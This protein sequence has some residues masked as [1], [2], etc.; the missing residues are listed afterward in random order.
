MET[1][2]TKLSL[3]LTG[4]LLVTDVLLRL[5]SLKSRASQP[6]KQRQQQLQALEARL[7]QAE[8]QL[9]RGDKHF[10]R[11]DAYIEVTA[12]ALLALLDH[13][14]RGNNIAQMEEAKKQLTE[15]ILHQ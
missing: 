4:F 10:R 1:L 14:T 15:Y 6:E 12:L 7:A 8:S 3:V 5:A 9:D 2:W 11:I 13:G